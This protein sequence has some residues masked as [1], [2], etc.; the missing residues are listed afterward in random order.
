MIWRTR[1]ITLSPWAC[2]QTSADPTEA[3]GT[4]VGKG[5]STSSMLTVTGSKSRIWA[6]DI[7][8][9]SRCG[10][11]ECLSECNQ[12]SAGIVVLSGCCAEIWNALYSSS[13]AC[14]G[15]FILDECAMHD[16]CTVQEVVWPSCCE[17]E[18]CRGC[19]NLDARIL[20]VYLLQ[21][22]CLCRNIHNS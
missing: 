20:T 14:L 17:A 2:D 6:W 15:V 3:R 4:C 22:M 19:G 12:A 13:L 9:S 8:F 10:V 5:F 7:K 18:V 21:S 11:L 1:I 16:L